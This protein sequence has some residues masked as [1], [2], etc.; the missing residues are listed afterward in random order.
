MKRITLKHIMWTA[1]IAAVILLFYN[2]LLGLISIIAVC[3]FEMTRLQKIKKKV[4]KD[5]EEEQKR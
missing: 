1:F 4:E 2:P 3:Y 5:L